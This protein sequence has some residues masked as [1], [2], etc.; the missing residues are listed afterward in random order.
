[1]VDAVTKERY[2]K[3]LVI[4]LAGYEADINRLMVTNAGLTSR[5]P[6]VINFRSLTPDECTDLLVHKLQRNQAR[7]KA[8]GKHL[9]TS[10]VEAQSSAFRTRISRLFGELSQGKDWASARDVK[11]ISTA[12]FR[13]MIQDKEGLA[14]GHF[15]IKMDVIEGELERMLQERRSRQADTENDKF[16][17]MDQL[18]PLFAPLNQDT[19]RPATTAATASSPKAPEADKDDAS[20]GKPD[21]AQ[22]Q[23]TAAV[24]RE[25]KE[26][27][28]DAGVSDAVWAQLQRDRQ[29][30]ARRGK[31]HEQLVVQ[32]RQAARDDD[33][34]ERAK[35][36]KRLLAEEEERRRKHE[37]ARQ[38]LVTM[39]LCPMKFAWVRQA[40]GYRCTGGSHYMSD[41]ELEKLM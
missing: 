27:V 13:K 9:D 31:E 35:V 24:P 38:K 23:R 22:E 19:L 17:F 26:A 6:E 1:M 40:E 10:V 18:P 32:A 15:A 33:D 5:F 34:A 4:I 8:K 36:V 11:E 29:V 28:R 41:A 16:R 21:A 37:A 25:A 3:K 14:T 20:K 39:G 12:V 2:A 7:L 30:E